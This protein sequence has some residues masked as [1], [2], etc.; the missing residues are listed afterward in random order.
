MGT[1]GVFG[2]K[3]NGKYYLTY[4]HFD[5]CPSGLGQVMVD[6]CKEFSRDNL[7]EKLEK[8]FSKV[9]L[10]SKNK[11]PTE[12][13]IEKYCK[14]GFCDLG[15]S[16]QTPE[17]WYCLLRRLQYGKAIRAILDGK[18]NHL[19]NN[20]DFFKDSPSCEYAY[21]MN[22]DTHCLEF[23]DGFNKKPDKNSPLSEKLVGMYLFEAIPDNWQYLFKK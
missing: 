20:F 23:Y 7:W 3:S 16:R 21:I 15:V 2:V 11:K 18:L 14:A 12:K 5:S 8:R 17:D 19:I 4:S 22:L 13:Q 9:V 1:R 10:V 6:M